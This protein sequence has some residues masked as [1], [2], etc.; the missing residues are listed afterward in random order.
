MFLQAESSISLSVGGRGGGNSRHSRA[1]LIVDSPLVS[2]FVITSLL[3]SLSHPSVC[4]AEIRLCGLCVLPSLLCPL[5]FKFCTNAEKAA[6]LSRNDYW[7]VFLVRYF[8]V[9]LFVCPYFLNLNICILCPLITCLSI[10]FFDSWYCRNFF[11]LFSLLRFIFYWR[12]SLS[13]MWRMLLPGVK[14]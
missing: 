6:L 14:V 2:V 10:F 8:V 13:R 3:H 12:E 9:F 4:F 5:N 1:K 7:L 11:L